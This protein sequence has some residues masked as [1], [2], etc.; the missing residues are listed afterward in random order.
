MTPE[1]FVARWRHADGSELANAQSFVRELCVLLQV[2]PPDPAH[3]DTADN[4]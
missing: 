3:A 2:P 1:D 4:A